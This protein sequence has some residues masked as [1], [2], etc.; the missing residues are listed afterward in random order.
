MRGER[1]DRP[2]ILALLAL[3]LAAAL[4]TVRAQEK[5]AEAQKNNG[6]TNRDY[7]IREE[8]T[9]E[10]FV[11]RQPEL[12]RKVLVRPDGKISL[13]LVQ[14]LQAAGLTPAELKKS[15]EEHLR[16]YLTEPNVT[17]IVD[18][19]S[20]YKVYVLGKVNSPG[21]YQLQAPI[22]ILQLIAMAGGYQQFASTDSIVI[23]RNNGSTPSILEFNYKEA[24]KGKNLDRNNVI[25]ERG[26]V[27]IV[28]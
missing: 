22:N 23:I 24:V 27:V 25:L 10:I 3:Y 9:L 19:T 8:D 11:W 13:P 7:V 12:S 4:G 5:A 6:A 20:S 28:P 2:V 14:D 26:D 17:V 18:S 21:V 16:K 1:Q 15:L